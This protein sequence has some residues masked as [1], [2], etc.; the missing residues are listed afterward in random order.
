MA[1]DDEA[2][3]IVESELPVPGTP[4]KVGRP[5]IVP[6]NSSGINPAVSC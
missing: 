6:F 5:K 4:D 2:P 1:A 3:L